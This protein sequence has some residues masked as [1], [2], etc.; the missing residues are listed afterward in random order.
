MNMLIE[1]IPKLFKASILT[2]ELTI[3]S[4]IIGIFIGLFFAILRLSK[5]KIIFNF[6][7]YYSFIFRGTPLLVQIF[8]IYFGLAQLDFIRDSFMWIVLKKPFACAIL[9]LS[10]NT[11]A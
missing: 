3:F 7:Y 2:I 5:N 9:A 11:G 4:L 6:A 10:L 8:I 1:N